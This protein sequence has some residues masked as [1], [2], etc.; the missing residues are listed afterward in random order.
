MLLHIFVSLALEA[1]ERHKFNYH[2]KKAVKETP[3][4]LENR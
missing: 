2:Q 3:S 4:P 1:L